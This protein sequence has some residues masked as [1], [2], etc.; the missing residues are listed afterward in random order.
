MVQ[1]LKALILVFAVMTV[2]G[3]IIYSFVLFI[4]FIVSLFKRK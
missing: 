3:W 4:K 2:A 1:A